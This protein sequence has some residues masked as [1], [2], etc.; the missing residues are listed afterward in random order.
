MPIANGFLT[1]KQFANEYFY[2]L[3]VG[4][5]NKCK[6]VQ[7]VNLVKR[8]RMFNK[9]YAFYS[10]TSKFMAEHFREY[11]NWVIENFLDKNKRPFVVELGS[12]DGIM[13]KHLAR[14]KIKHLGVEPSSNVANVARKQGINTIS[15]F[16]E[17]SLAKKI[18]K[19]YGQ[20]DVILGANVICHIPYLNSLV[21]GVK[22][23]LKDDGV[24]IFEEPYLGD[25]INKTS[26]DQI[27]DEHAFYFSVLSL[28]N[29]FRRHGLAIVDVYPQ[30]VHGGSMRYVVSKA[31]S[32]TKLH[33]V[34]RQI[35]LEKKNGLDK[36]AAFIKLAERIED[37][38]KSL[39]DLLFDLKRLGKRVVGYGATSKSTTVINFC[40]IKDEIEYIC[41]TTPA[42]IGKFSPGAHI[43]IKPYED[44]YGHYPDYALLFAW[45]HKKEI[46]EKEGRFAKSG[47]KWILFVPKVHILG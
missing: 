29:V 34:D 14:R 26:Y 23:L 44:F 31:G 39:K 46:L 45:N 38:K 5:C 7:L 30:S 18:L 12:N 28:T 6:M 17:E 27:Y 16:F 24:F 19:K 33:R 22:I 37:S 42:K 9:N 11:A 32:R 41:D 21:R 10:S 2:D 4:F 8:E 35:D 13:L 3:A 15:E 40:G 20:A 36:I 25:I 1:K 43:L 47:G